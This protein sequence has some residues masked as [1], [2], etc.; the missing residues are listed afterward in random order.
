MPAAGKEVEKIH[1]SIRF[2][3]PV[4]VKRLRSTLEEASPEAP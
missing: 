1:S 2:L 4:V 3:K